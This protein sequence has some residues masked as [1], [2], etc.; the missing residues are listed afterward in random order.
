MTMT[1]A[2]DLAARNVGID[3]PEGFRPDQADLFA[4]NSAG[5]RFRWKTFGLDV[6]GTVAEFEPGSRLA[7]YGE[8]DGPRAYHT[9]PLLHLPDGCQVITE[10]VGKGPLALSLAATDPGVLHRGHDL[11]NAT[12]KRISES[13][14]DGMTGD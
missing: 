12:L 8:G 14:V 3:W 5:A 6:V 10:E 13:D 4:H 2:A 1:I 7:W 9:W 11:W